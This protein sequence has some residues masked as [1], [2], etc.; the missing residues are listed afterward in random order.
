GA[1]SLRKYKFIKYFAI[2]ILTFLL[3]NLI[4]LT[5]ANFYMEFYGLIVIMGVLWLTNIGR[6]GMVL[7]SVVIIL[8]LYGNIAILHNDYSQATGPIIPASDKLKLVGNIAKSCLVNN[9]SYISTVN[10]WRTFYYFGRPVLPGIEGNLWT[11]K[12]AIELYARGELRNEV[13]L[14]HF[15][16][17]EIPEELDK[18]L[19]KIA[20]RKY[21]FEKDRLLIFK[22]CD[23]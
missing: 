13:F 23:I 5:T 8:N 21:V 3:I 11:A 17:E 19:E 15:K 10:P 1:F 14:I 6:I 9:E 2:I 20:K 22:E 7:L 16:E 12:E 18:N 4:K